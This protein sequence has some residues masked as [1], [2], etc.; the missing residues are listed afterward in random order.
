MPLIG[1]PKLHPSWRSFRRVQ[2][3]K[4][5]H[6]SQSRPCSFDYVDGD[7]LWPAH[8]I[9]LNPH[10]RCG[11]GGWVGSF[12]LFSYAKFYFI[13][14]WLWVDGW[15]DFKWVFHIGYVPTPVTSF[16]CLSPHGVS[17]SFLRNWK[18]FRLISFLWQKFVCNC[19]WIFSDQRRLSSD[20]T[21]TCI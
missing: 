1:Y 14:V 15:T 4:T 13:P 7:E 8:V 18:L 17:V 16:F 10:E 21:I 11:G 5:F 3:A 6:I 12:V 9:S 19:M 20:L 2:N